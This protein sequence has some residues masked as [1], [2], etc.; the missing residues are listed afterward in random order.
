MALQSETNLRSFLALAWPIVVARATQAVIGFSDAA[1]TA[2][3]GEEALAA[4]TTGALNTM[5]IIIFPMGVMFLVQSFAAQLQ[6]RGEAPSAR[7]YA[8]YGL[9]FA[10]AVQIIT[11]SAFGF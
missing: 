7:R 11:L 4:T 2:P 1:L 6:G 9:A 5:S 8:I 3:L 10:A